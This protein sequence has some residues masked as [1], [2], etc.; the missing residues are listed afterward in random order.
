MLSYRI[1]PV[2]VIDF[3]CGLLT[4]MNSSS[5]TAWNQRLTYIPGTT[6]SE[7]FIKTIFSNISSGTYVSIVIFVES[8]HF[9]GSI[10][11]IQHKDHPVWNFPYRLHTY[12]ASL[13]KPNR[14]H[15]HK[16][17]TLFCFLEVLSNI[18]C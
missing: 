17:F 16:R 14:D 7:N 11:M 12:Y 4:N 18:Y 9:K 2:L 1:R 3:D 5:L 10:A 6:T 15:L 13:T 8:Y